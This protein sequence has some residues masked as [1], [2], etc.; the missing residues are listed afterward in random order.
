M[1]IDILKETLNRFAPVESGRNVTGKAGLAG[2]L[3][4]KL[5][6]KLS[7]GLDS[8]W[9]CLMVNWWAS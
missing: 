3:A 7:S 5:V 4:G 6:G 8:W 9:A 1:P 2:E